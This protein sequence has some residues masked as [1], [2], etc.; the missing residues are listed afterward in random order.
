MLNILFIKIR[1]NKI[2][3]VAINYKIQY[4]IAL[5]ILILNIDLSIDDWIRNCIDEQEQDIIRYYF[6]NQIQITPLK[7]VDRQDLKL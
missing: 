4:I 6:C 2:K 5:N 1:G 7:H 3:Y